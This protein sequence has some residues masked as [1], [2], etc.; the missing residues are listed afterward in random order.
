MCVD[1]KLHEEI[2]TFILVGGKTIDLPVVSYKFKKIEGLSNN[3]MK[4]NFQKS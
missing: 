3:F 4:H 2:T 1:T